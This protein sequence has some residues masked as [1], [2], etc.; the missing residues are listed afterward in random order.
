MYLLLKS[1]QATA[2]E[3]TAADLLD[4]GGDSTSAIQSHP[5]VARLQQLNKLAQKLED[6]VENKV[7]TLSEQVD[8]LVKASDMMNA[9]ENDE[10][11]EAESD[12]SGERASLEGTPV[13]EK[14]DAPAAAVSTSSEEDS[15][16][17][18]ATEVM[19]EARFGLRPQELAMQEDEED[20]RPRRAAPVD[21]GDEE[22]DGLTRKAAQSLAS[23]IN[24][25]EQRSATLSRKKRLA[26]MAETLDEHEDE[27]EAFRQGLAMMEEDLGRESDNELEKSAELDEEL[28][29]DVDENDFYNSVK[30]NSQ[31]KKKRKAA[32]Y[33]VAPKYPGI[34]ADIEGTF[35]DF[36]F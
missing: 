13:K 19:N 34:D 28:D 18:I 32:Q 24:T 22:G 26:G 8:Y 4:V 30:K 21:F 27:N 23:T 3:D 36:F 10:N 31:A 35:I 7:E 17:D 9:E 1:E 6:R 2:Q 33:M 15:E 20:R 25:I 14:S 12:E 16:D 29:D 11:S 5:V